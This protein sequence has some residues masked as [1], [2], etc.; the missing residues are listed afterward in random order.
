MRSAFL[1]FGFLSLVMNGQEKLESFQLPAY[2][3][4]RSQLVNLKPG[5]MIRVAADREGEL[6][7]AIFIYEATAGLMAKNDESSDVEGFEWVAT[8][9]G[10]FRVQIYSRSPQA[11]EYRI[12]RY[13]PE[14]ARDAIVAGKPVLAVVPVYYATNRTILSSNPVSFGADPAGQGQVRFGKVE[15]SIPLDHRRGNIEYPSFLRLWFGPDPSRHFV[16]GS[17]LLLDKNVFYGELARLVSRSDEQ[18][19]L[20][21]VHGFNTTFEDA[22]LRVAQL[23][24]DLEFKGPAILFAWP[25]QGKLLDYLKDGRNADVSAGPLKDLLTSLS[26]TSH[27]RRIH[28]IAHSMGNR[29]LSN[30][31]TK[32]APPLPSIRE[33]ALIAPDID[34]ALFQEL[35]E[36]FPKDV[37]PI[38]LYAS[39]K[40]AALLA[41]KS[42]TGYARAGQGGKDM[43]VLPGIDSIDASAVDTSALG[44]GHQYFAD[45]RDILADLYWFFRGQP[46]NHRHA[47]RPSPDRRYWIFAP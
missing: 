33:I 5:D 11:V 24:Y 26:V 30:A 35:A 39:S 47:L 43:L 10:Q 3:A 14:P 17:A 18:D 8:Q 19:A 20:V 15:V 29:V 27:V 16:A 4:A 2:G 12:I 45:S 22:C 38:G 7:P 21:F 28:V 23:A 34:A 1:F 46:P 31:L 41:S 36:R 13:P 9:A 32:M 25:S 37:G 42:L 44:M 6:N 40:D